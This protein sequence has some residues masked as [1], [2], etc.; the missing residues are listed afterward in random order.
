M[1]NAIIIGASSGIGRELSRV[2]AS[3]GYNVG[4]AARRVE[5][6]QQV[7]HGIPTKAFVKIIDISQPVEAMRSLRELIAEMKD[8]DL[9]VISSGT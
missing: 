1:P 2:L 5:L 8:I 6:L 3:H 9:F 7:A 4:L